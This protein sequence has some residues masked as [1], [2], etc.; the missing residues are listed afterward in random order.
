L[1]RQRSS[2]A[3]IRTI[4]EE[5]LGLES[6]YVN[7]VEELKKFFRI[8]EASSQEK[9]SYYNVAVKVEKAMH[10]EIKRVKRFNGE[11]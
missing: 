9:L 8:D 4:R 7:E 11:Y 2:S 1:A 3:S 5:V 6:S 10:R